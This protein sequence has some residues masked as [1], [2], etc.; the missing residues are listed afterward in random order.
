MG[1]IQVAATIVDVGDH[2]EAKQAALKAHHSQI[3][4]E[5]FFLNVPDDMVAA[6]YGTEAF[7]RVRSD[8][9]LP[10]GLETDLFTG[11]A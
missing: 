7:V 10:D 1:E 5:S 11:L 8:A 6:F 9:A 2:I 4:P 3:S